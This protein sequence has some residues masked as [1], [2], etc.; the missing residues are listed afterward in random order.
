MIRILTEDI[1]R[2]NIHGALASASVDAYTLIPCEG[3]WKGVR[4]KSLIIELD[5]I[6]RFRAICI[7]R[8][9]KDANKQEAVLIQE[10]H[11]TSTLI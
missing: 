3:S 11:A 2:S 5:G 6:S 7:A 9:I 8:R 1:N 10:I 4:E